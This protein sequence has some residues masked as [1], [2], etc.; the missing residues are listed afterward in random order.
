MKKDSSQLRLYPDEIPQKKLKELIKSPMDLSALCRRSRKPLLITD[1]YE[2]FPTLAQWTPDFLNEK[3][4]DKIV[5]VNSSDTDVFQEY[6][7]AMKMSL[8]EYSRQISLNSSGVGRRLYMGSLGIHQFLPEIEPDLLFDRLLPDETKHSDLW[9][10]PGDN[11]TGLHYDPF[12]NFFMQL[13]GEKRWLLTEPN[14]FLNLHPRSALSSYPRVSDFNPS[15]PDF[16]KFHKAKKVKFYDLRIKSGSIL[17]VPPYWWHQVTSF[18][19]SISVSVWC[20]TSLI[21][22]EWG[23]LQLLPTHIKYFMKH[24]LLAGRN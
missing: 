18:S 11:T 8:R 2:V 16:E 13:F 14:S 15:T 5:E 7:P 19:T 17:F 3:V 12:N 22:A 9:Y 10:G 21:K 6:R 24:Y 20:R 4:G 23:A 1:I